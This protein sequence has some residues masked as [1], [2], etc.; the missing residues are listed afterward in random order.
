MFTRDSF[1]SLYIDGEKKNY[2]YKKKQKT[3]T[4]F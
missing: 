3:K 4:N 1:I 2:S